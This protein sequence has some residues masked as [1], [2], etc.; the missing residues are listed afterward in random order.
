MNRR[1][2][3]N[4]IQVTVDSDLREWVVEEAKREALTVASYVR[5]LLLE[6]CKR[7]RTTDH[8]RVAEA[9][10]CAGVVPIC[11]KC[12]HCE[13]GGLMVKHSEPFAVSHRYLSTH[14]LHVGVYFCMRCSYVRLHIE[15]SHPQRA[16][17][18]LTRIK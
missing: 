1:T 11:P 6:T 3:L 12:A 5:K 18:H 16:G 4:L 8:E 15:E 17:T 7:S 2:K 9:Q 10:E 14:G 13:D